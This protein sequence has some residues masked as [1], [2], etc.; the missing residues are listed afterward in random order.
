MKPVV[1][2]DTLHYKAIHMVLDWLALFISGSPRNSADRKLYRSNASHS[3][4]LST[5][6]A[7]FISRSAW[8]Q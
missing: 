1:P 7:A 6:H 2:A 4:T 5:V 3:P 8:A